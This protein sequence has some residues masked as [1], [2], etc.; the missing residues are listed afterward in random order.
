[1]S[2]GQRHATTSRE[3]TDLLED[4]FRPRPEVLVLHD[5]KHL[6]GPGHP[7][8]SPD[9]S[10][11]RGVRV[12]DADRESFDVV[13][14]G[15]IPCLVIEVVSPYSA[16]IRR[17]DLEDKVR[18]YEA[19][20]IFEYL[21]VD[22]PRW[23]AGRGYSLLGY[24]LDAAGKYQPIAPDAEGRVLSQATGISF[25]AA[26]D[27]QRVLLVETSTGRR[28]MGLS[29]WKAEAL[30]REEAL[31]SA[32]DELARLRAEMERLRGGG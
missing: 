20:G 8:P 31:R 17:T 19:A 12:H 26:P 29:E 18:L 30:R 9:V 2:Q 6:L 21:I 25:Q 5:V 23:G 15:V 10:V 1:M 16:R 27:R 14:E 28:L 22:S 24:R 11:I 3:I 4:Y 32:E 13:E 7:A